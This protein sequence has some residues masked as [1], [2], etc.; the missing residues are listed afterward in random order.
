[1]AKRPISYT[2]RDFESIKNDLVNYAKRYYPSTYRDFNEAS[3][4]ALM[5]DLVSYVGDQLSFYVDYQANESFLDSAIETK[6]IVRLAQQLGYNIKGAP[7][8]TGICTFYIIIPAS[9]NSRGPDPRYLPIL[10][11]GTLIGAAGGAYY[12]LNGDVDFSAGTNEITVARV[13]DDTG[14]PTWFAVQAYGSVVS[15][16]R[17][18]EIISVGDYRRFRRL[19]LARS[20]VNEIIEVKDAQGNEYYQVD[21]LSEDIIYKEETNFGSTRD[22]VSSIMRVVPVPR[23]FVVE[24]DLDGTA[25]LQFGYGSADNLTGDVIADPADVVL[26]VTG[27]DYISDQ[28]FDPSNLIKTDKFGVVPVNT[29]LTIGYS[30][31][32]GNSV[33]AA[34]NTVNSAITPNFVFENRDSLDNGSVQSVIESLEVANESPIL[35]DTSEESPEEVRI[36]AYASFASQNRAVTKTDYI[37]LAYRMPAKFGSVKRVNLIQDRDS[38]K[39]NLN[40]YVLSEDPDGNFI[41]P[42]STL[43]KNLRMWLLKKKMLNDTIDIMDGVVINYGV[44]FEVLPDLD[45]NRYELLQ[46]CVSELKNKLSVKKNIGEAIYVSE[47]YKFLNDVPGVIDA[48]SVEL[49]NQAGGIYSNFIYDVETHLS[50]DGRYLIVPPWAVAEIL[51]PNDDIVGVVK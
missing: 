7:K 1:M 34:M 4:G 39:R 44:R 26:D 49:Y 3:F 47:I 29:T 19:S 30:A 20:G 35:G 50:D 16:R 23:R 51:V 22:T 9:A 25:N 43:K 8:A 32:V 6:N 41:A 10:K 17:F 31:N 18:E 36:R 24:Y 46:K 2:S 5:L 27:R 45:V 37:S 42:N 11:S 12:T 15:G 28:T 33:N 13:D 14:N 40:M 21:H 38:F 48:T